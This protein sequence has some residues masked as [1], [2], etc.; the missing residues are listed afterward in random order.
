VVKNDKNDIKTVKYYQLL[1]VNKL[2][3]YSIEQRETPPT[4]KEIRNKRELMELGNVPLPLNK[5]RRII[6]PNLFS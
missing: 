5:K 1:K 4:F 2:D 3:R 6:K